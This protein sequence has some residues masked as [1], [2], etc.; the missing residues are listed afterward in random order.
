MLYVQAQE[1]CISKGASARAPHCS[2]GLDDIHLHNCHR[3]HR[4]L[5]HAQWWRQQIRVHHVGHLLLVS[6]ASNSYDHTFI[7]GSVMCLAQT[8]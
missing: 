5:D 1:V 6:M 8:G 2:C 3:P 4:C 7:C